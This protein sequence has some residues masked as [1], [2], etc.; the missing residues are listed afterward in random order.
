M[1][2]AAKKDAAYG[3]LKEALGHVIPEEAV[4]TV[5]AEQG[6]VKDAD[7]TKALQQKL[8]FL[9]REEAAIRSE[10]ARSEETERASARSAAA[11]KIVK[12]CVLS[13]LR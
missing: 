10:L 12:V 7:P 11:K 9:K 8:E 2:V 13:G 5:A 6:T 1:D 4:D 3:K